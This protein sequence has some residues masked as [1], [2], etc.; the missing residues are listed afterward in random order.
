MSAAAVVDRV[1]SHDVRR[2]APLVRDARVISSASSLERA[3]QHVG[4][5]EHVG[6]G[7]LRERGVATRSATVVRSSVITSV[8]HERVEYRC[9]VAPSGCR[10]VNVRDARADRRCRSS[11]PRGGG[12][13]R[14]FA[15]FRSCS[16]CRPRGRPAAAPA[17]RCRRSAWARS[18]AP[19]GGSRGR[20]RRDRGSGREPSPPRPRAVASP[21]RPF[22][23]ACRPARPGV[24]Y[25]RPDIVHSAGV[26]PA[27]SPSTRRPP[28]ITSTVAAS[29]AISNGPRTP[30]FST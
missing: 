5:A 25:S 10:V 7:S 22:P 24:G 21:R 23:R 9:A 16:R 18:A 13:L 26:C 11:R 17:R 20:R 19:V 6:G 15:P 1:G 28:E 27:P 30:A 3:D 4:R 2:E 12:R 8:L 14:G 29:L